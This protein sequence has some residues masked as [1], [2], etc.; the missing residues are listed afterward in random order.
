MQITVD[1][2]RYAVNLVDTAGQEEYRQMLDQR[3]RDADG[4]IVAYVLLFV[5]LLTLDS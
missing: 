1:G 5:E 4:F 2:R 3:A